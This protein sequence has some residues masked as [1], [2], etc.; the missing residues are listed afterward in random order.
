MLSI[1]KVA[2]D[3]KTY[4]LEQIAD[5][6]E[7]YYSGRGEAD[8][9]WIGIEIGT[10]ELG[11]KVRSQEFLQLLEG[12]R[13]PKTNE[14][15]AK[16]FTRRENLAYDFTFS[17]PKSVSLMYAAGDQ[18]VKAQVIEA[19]DAAVRAGYAYMEGAANWGRARQNGEL[20][21]F[22]GGG[23][24]G[25]AFRHRT[26]RLGEPNLHSHVVT[27]NMIQI[28][29]DRWTTLDSKR[30]YNHAKAGGT[31]YQSALRRELTRRLG[32]EWGEVTKGQADVAGISREVIE[33]F[34]TRAEQ[35]QA[36]MHE[37]GFSSIVQGKA[38]AVKTRLSKEQSKVKEDMFEAWKEE[39]ERNG[40]TPE[41]IRELCGQQPRIRNVS[42]A[43]EN[44]I[45]KTL[46]DDGVLTATRSYT[47]RRRVIEAIADI[48]PATASPA[49]IERMADTWIREHGVVLSERGHGPVAEAKK[50]IAAGN[51]AVT[52]QAHLALEDRVLSSML[53]RVDNGAGVVNDKVLE[54]GLRV[55]A[56][57]LSDEQRQ[58]VESVL[59]SGNGVDVVVGDAGTGKTFALN[60]LRKIYQDA[61]YEVVGAALAARA[62]RELGDGA[63]INSETVH[64]TLRL[65][66]RESE[67]EKSAKSDGSKTVLLIDEAGMLDTELL[68]RVLDHR[69][70]RAMKIVLVG[71]D[72]QLPPIGPGGVFRAAAD[73]LGYSRL[74]EN[75]RQRDKIDQEIVADFRDGRGAAGLERAR[76]HGRLSLV[77]SHDEALNAIYQGWSAE[78]DPSKSLM[79]A[80]LREEVRELNLRA[81]ADRIERGEL[82]ETELRCG[83]YAYRVGDVVRCGQRDT[84]FQVANGDFGTVVAVDTEKR[85]LT[86][87]VSINGVK[88]D[89]TLATDYVTDPERLR[90]GYA[91]TAHTAQGATCESAWTLMNDR[92]YRELGYTQ[93]SRAK[94]Q[95]HVVVVGAP[96]IDPDRPGYDPAHDVTE[97][98]LVVASLQN[99]QA[100]AMALDV[101]APNLFAG[102]GTRALVEDVAAGR[103]KLR[104]KIAEAID[105]EAGKGGEGQQVPMKP[106]WLKPDPESAQ[107]YRDLVNEVKLRTEHRV[108]ELMEE[109]PRYLIRELGEVPED[110]A[111]REYW[112]RG[113]MEVELYRTRWE[114][115]DTAEAFG[116]KS[117][118]KSPFADKAYDEAKRIQRLGS[119]KRMRKQKDAIEAAPVSMKGRSL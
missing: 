32:V 61:G 72:K 101:G 11:G 113:A 31:I 5:S 30:I 118:A 88:K 59:R 73:R 114:I 66:D 63:E 84:S 75:R 36:D 20:H 55:H 14:L 37:L 69:S 111:Q 34:S 48:A 6:A 17:A 117:R 64:R 62:A 110:H 44:A 33:N 9:H 65:F 4:H 29:P 90:L 108:R 83:V 12:V 58:M 52:T 94:G 51:R 99:S 43:Q 78:P 10:Y 82:G 80:G 42:K 49:E 106:E 19:H 25:A 68:A 45:L 107:H 74:T 96:V 35:I 47:D 39:L 102:V 115:V 38:S 100:Q 91:I 87:E 93:I 85:E 8:G 97:L 98:E 56:K 77:N 119:F 15:Y 50:L 79:I 26:N 109:P 105:A 57:P 1:G 22:Q 86:I 112:R 27:P 76:L 28:G 60:A 3:N 116:I 92:T 40:L 7:E 67:N 18:Q 95:T 13:E 81:Q 16:S 70:S 21:A 2:P 53:D 71:D 54:H 103:E 41:S 23:L 24:F 46:E 89:V 104:A